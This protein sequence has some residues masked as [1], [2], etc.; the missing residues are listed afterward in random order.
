MNEWVKSSLSGLCGVVVGVLSSWFIAQQQQSF[1]KE[2]QTLDLTR[3]LS[4]QFSNGIY[5]QVSIALDG[6]QKLYIEEGGKFGHYDINKYLDFFE[7]L[8]F[9]EDKGILNDDLINT[10]FGPYVIQ[11]H[12]NIELEGYMYGLRKN[13]GQPEAFQKFEVLAKKLEEMPNNKALL[14][15]LK[16]NRRCN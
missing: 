11:A 7:N 9:Y 14:D 6:C 16:Q 15:K 3:E 10:F 2:M 4:E 1:Y 12:Q 5:K 8:A 13:Y